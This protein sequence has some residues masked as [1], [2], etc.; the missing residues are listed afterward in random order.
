MND[1]CFSNIGLFLFIYSAMFSLRQNKNPTFPL[2]P[3]ASTFKQ[4]QVFTAVEKNHAQVIFLLCFRLQFYFNLNKDFQLLAEK[5]YC[6]VYGG[7]CAL[8]SGK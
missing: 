4:T 5:I 2:G 1:N 7:F 8:W 6:L 3:I